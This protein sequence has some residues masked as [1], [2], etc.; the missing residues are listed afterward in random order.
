M[1]GF[2]EEVVLTFHQRREYVESREAALQLE[3]VGTVAG[4]P[5]LVEFGQSSRSGKGGHREMPL[6][7]G[8]G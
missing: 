8:P 4:G 5:G 1:A 7:C 2:Q 3:A 6:S